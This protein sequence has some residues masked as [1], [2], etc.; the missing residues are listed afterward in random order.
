MLS[1]AGYCVISY[2]LG[3]GDR[4]L[5]NIMITKSGHLFHIDFSFLLGQKSKLLAHE[6]KITPDMIDAMGGEKSSYYKE[7]QDVCSKAYNC[8]RRHTNLFYVLLSTLSNSDPVIDEGKFTKKYVKEQILCRFLPGESSQEAK[9]IFKTK[10]KKKYSYGEK[11]IDFCHKQNKTGLISSI[12][13][14]IQYTQTLKKNFLELVSPEK[15]NKNFITNINKMVTKD[16]EYG[17]ENNPFKEDVSSIKNKS[18]DNT[19]NTDTTNTNTT[20][21]SL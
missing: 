14:A 5:D 21:D 3:I 20:T 13:T 6:I 19:A 4:H 2:V 17:K 12:N 9:L 16:A 15:D 1:C 8:I 18:S 11:I 10:I 7:F